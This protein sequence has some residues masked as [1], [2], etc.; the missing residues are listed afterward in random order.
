MP[1]P[2][3]GTEASYRS[4]NA[5]LYSAAFLSGLVTLAVE[6]AA[7]RLIS[8]IFSNSNVVWAGVIGMTLLYLTVGY[9]L[10]GRWAD[11]R[12]SPAAFLW[13]VAWTALAV[14]VM[15]AVAL[16]LLRLAAEAIQY[17]D[18]AVAFGAAAGI[19]VLF[20]APVTL[21]GCHPPFI[22][23]LCMRRVSRSGDV[24]GRVYA[25]STLG[26]LLGAFGAVF[27]AIPWIGTA[28]T[29]LLGA[30]L[31]MA[32]ALAGLWLTKAGRAARAAWMPLA[33]GL[34]ALFALQRPLKAPP[35]G[36]LLLYEDETAYNYLQVVERDGTRYLLINE[37]LA[38]HSVYH[39]TELVTNGS[40][41][42][43][44]A[45][46]YFN[47][48]TYRPDRVQKVAF[49]GLAAGTSARQFT[50]VYGP[51]QIDGVEIDPDIVEVGRRYFGMTLPNLNVIVQDARFALTRM[52]HGYQVIGVD[53]YRPPYIPWQL[54]TR[55]FFAEVRAH[56][57]DDG[58]VMINVG[59][60]QADRRL[61][62]AMTATL[63][64]VF[65]SAHT[66]DVEASFN[67]MIV[68][69]VQPTTAENLRLNLAGLDAG[70]H[71]FL[72]Y[73][74]ELSQR[75]LRPTVA[76][77][78]VFTDERAPVEFIADSLV[79]SFALEGGGA[80]FPAGPAE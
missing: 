73:A 14:A 16:P 24:A 60:T 72:R 76:S 13:L 6:F 62:E 80:Q 68:A 51:I 23:R 47:A 30:A 54:T 21:L 8:S 28:A 55:E 39:P 48:P 64:D 29:F 2:A 19:A 35:A 22:I 15:P 57:A 31:L 43:F 50:E 3:A 33:L 11:R 63:L 59:R 69:T 67:S 36:T 70:A 49:L 26:G 78:L 56:L 40:W 7:G 75:S 18:L 38:V 46:P 20:A 5:L 44:V 17:F 4:V 32:A 77:G 34:L 74:L 52:D 10:G 12:P 25:L 71:P 65:P 66:L 45:A 37:T 41:D 58:V 42:Y 79:L 9:F 27:V 53:A 61:V 1:N